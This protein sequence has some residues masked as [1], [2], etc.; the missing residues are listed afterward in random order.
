MNKIKE[1]LGSV[2]SQTLTIIKTKLESLPKSQ[3]AYAVV[4]KP[5]TTNTSGVG[6]VVNETE[7]EPQ[8]ADQTVA[9]VVADV[10][11]EAEPQSKI[12]VQAVADD[13][14]N[15]VRTEILITDITEIAATDGS[16]HS[17]TTAPEDSVLR[18]HFLAN[19]HAMTESLYGSRPEDSVLAR[20][21][22]TAVNS[23]IE[24]CLRCDKAIETLAD[25]FASQQHA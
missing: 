8:N 10:R 13:V 15:D 22:D 1:I 12:V 3:S 14:V 4:P 23:R 7:P 21:Y 11:D 18:R 2:L 24:Q 16:E 17:H 25:D 9:E 20:H 5:K 6:Q 19:L